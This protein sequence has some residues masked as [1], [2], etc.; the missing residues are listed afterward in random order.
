MRSVWLN[1]RIL[2]IRGVDSIIGFR[3]LQ[4]ISDPFLS[5]G[6]T[7]LTCSRCGRCQSVCNCGAKPLMILWRSSWR[8]CSWVCMALFSFSCAEFLTDPTCE[9]FV[10]WEND[11][12]KGNFSKTL[13]NILNFLH[14]LGQ[15]D[16]LVD[17]PILSTHS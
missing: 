2:K 8:R 9:R 12:L 6:S 14:Y 3:M 4:W 16:L 10:R 1:P 11:V 7:H 17:K 5:V 13:S 15:V